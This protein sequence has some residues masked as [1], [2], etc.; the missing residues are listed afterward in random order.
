LSTF[1]LFLDL[2]GGYI[3]NLLA[4]FRIFPAR[5]AV[6]LSRTVQNVSIRRLTRFHALSEV[7]DRFFTRRCS[8]SH[9]SSG[10]IIPF[11]TPLHR[12]ATQNSGDIQKP[13]IGRSTLRHAPSTALSLL[14]HAPLCSAHDI[15]GPANRQIRRRRFQICLDLRHQSPHA[16]S[17]TSSLLAHAPTRLCAPPATSAALPIGRSGAADSRSAS[18]SAI[19]V[20][21]RCHAPPSFSARG[22]HAPGRLP[23]AASFSG[24]LR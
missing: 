17:T 2:S 23:P 19:G 8:A 5:S 21:T 10:P 9:R 6:G 13:P 20:S 12:S 11:S 24:H 3:V 7:L 15:R 1:S 18:I 22:S 4:S 14:A 16:P